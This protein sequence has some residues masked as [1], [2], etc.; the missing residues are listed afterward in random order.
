MKIEERIEKLNRILSGIKGMKQLPDIVFIVD[1]RK[2]RIAISEAR[3]LEIPIVGVVDTNCDPDEVD[4]VIPGNDDAIRAIKLISNKIAEAIIE[5]KGY[6]FAEEETAEES[7]TAQASLVTEEEM[8]A[9]PDAEGDA[10]VTTAA[11]TVAAPDAYD[12]EEVKIEQAMEEDR[13]R[14]EPDR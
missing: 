4:Y 5:V 9:A 2:E 1:P 11:E 8:A 7:A 6:E 3:K 10:E 13:R 14:T 12:E